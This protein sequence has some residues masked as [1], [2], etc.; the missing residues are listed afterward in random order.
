MLTRTGSPP[1]GGCFAEEKEFTGLRDRLSQQRRDLPWER[2]ERTMFSIAPLA[3][4]PWHSYQRQHQLA[5]YDFMLG[6]G[7]KGCKSCSYWADNFNGIDM[8]LARRDVRFLVILACAV[9]GDRRPL[10][11]ASDETSKWVSS[12]GSNFNY[13]YHVS[14]RPEQLAPESRIQLCPSKMRMRGEQPG[15]SVFYKDDDGRISSHLLVP[16]RAAL[17]MM[18]GA[19]HGSASIPRA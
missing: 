13:D 10:R 3:G 17:D 16:T 1:G 5:I 9:A 4:K 6:Q 2:V 12:F 19:Y 15:I 7:W 11:T 8:P 18:N 14:I